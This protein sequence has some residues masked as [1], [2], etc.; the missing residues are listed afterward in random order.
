MSTPANAEALLR[1]IIAELPGR[2]DLSSVSIG[3]GAMREGEPRAS[4]GNCDVTLGHI[5]W[6]DITGRGNCQSSPDLLSFVHNGDGTYLKVAFKCARAHVLYSLSDYEKEKFIK[7]HFL[8]Y[9]GLYVLIFNMFRDM[10]GRSSSGRLSVT[11]IFYL[12]SAM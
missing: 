12:Y 2:Y 11:K 5:P 4:G 7:V 1:N 8:T 3:P 6:D 10:P 9:T